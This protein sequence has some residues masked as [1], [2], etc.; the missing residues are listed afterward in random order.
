MMADRLG[1]LL[2]LLALVVV[3][4]SAPALAQS[5]PPLTIAAASDMRFAMD[6]LCAK[7]RARHPDDTV[8][9]VYGSS[10][11]FSAQIEHGAPF[12]LFFSAD[13]AYPMHLHRR[14]Q[15]ASAPRRYGLGRLAIWVDGDRALPPDIA[16]LAAP[17]FARIAIAN[18]LHA[19]YGQRAEQALRRAGAWDALESRLVR[20]ENV[21][22][23]AHLVRSGAADAG[24]VALALVSSDE[25][26]GR[27]RHRLVD[28]AL[29]EPLWQAFIVTRRAGTDP[30]ALRFAD[31]VGSAEGRAVLARFGFVVPPDH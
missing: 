21:S 7:Y 11:K 23:A 31:F 24:I 18:P 30:R 13:E 25:L 14:G 10:G 2:T 4:A 28:D 5:P 27:G 6:A 26:A 9:V 12:D 20:A 17:E 29:H 16:G 22:Q 8:R 3:L 19:P 1:R 15:A